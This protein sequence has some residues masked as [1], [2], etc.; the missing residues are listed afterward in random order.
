MTEQLASLFADESTS[1]RQ[2]GG[3]RRAG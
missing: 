3:L 1:R 2:P